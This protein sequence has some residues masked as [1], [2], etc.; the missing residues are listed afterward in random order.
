VNPFSLTIPCSTTNLGAGFDAIGIAL[1]A[2]SLRV[3][4]R[5]GG[6]GLRIVELSGEG[7]GK[8]P[9]DATNR[10]I[11]AAVQAAGWAGRGAEELDAELAIDNEI[12]IARGLGSSAAA[13]LAGA[14]LADELLGG[15]CG[16]R[17]ILATCL[18]LEGHPDNI[19]ASLRGGAQVA[20]RDAAGHVIFCPISFGAPLKAALFVPEQPLSTAT[21]RSVLPREVPLADAVHNL[22]RSALF[23]AAL[24]AGRLDLL[25]EAMEDRLHQ[26]PRTRL[27]PWLPDLMA[28]ARGAGAAGASLSGAGTSVFSLCAPERAEAVAGALTARAQRLGVPGRAV[29]CEA[30]VAGA[31]VK[32]ESS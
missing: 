2:F 25:G 4:V 26:M 11:A 16:E 23:V 27:M 18:S 28:A 7:V 30:G 15:D 14:L 10:V 22:G 13:A 29:I 19:A 9:R 21:A 6:D 17:G 24:G 31:K 12:P 1:G 20:V 8:L 32:R 5:P 3:K